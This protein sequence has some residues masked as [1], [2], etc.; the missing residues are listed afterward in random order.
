MI[1]IGTEQGTDEPIFDSR[2]PTGPYE[3]VKMPFWADLMLWKHLA[4]LEQ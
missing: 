4:T 1:E 2:H 3:R